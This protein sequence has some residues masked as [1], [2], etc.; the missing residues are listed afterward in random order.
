MD[1]KSN[2]VIDQE[3]C[4]DVLLIYFQEIQ[5]NKDSH[6]TQNK[7]RYS[8]KKMLEKVFTHHALYTFYASTIWSYLYFCSAFIITF[9][10]HQQLRTAIHKQKKIN[11]N[12]KYQN[13]NQNDGFTII[14]IKISASNLFYLSI[15]YAYQI[16]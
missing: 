14:M 7:E 10:T 13:R 1:G 16:K 12:W 4:G 11:S 3:N 6:D 15:R 8:N 2:A 5:A 9:Q